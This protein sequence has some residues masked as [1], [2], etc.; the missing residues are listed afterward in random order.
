MNDAK[1]TAPGLPR[2]RC[3]K[4]VEAAR[5]T[6]V[7]SP[8][9]RLQTKDWT[10]HLGDAGSVAVGSAWMG[11]HAPEVGGYYVRYADDY[12]SFSPADAFEGGYTLLENP[13]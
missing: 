8:P 6:E 2:Y 11:K 12:E 1:T 3:H 10:L 5:I 9:D 4:E 13:P 7:V